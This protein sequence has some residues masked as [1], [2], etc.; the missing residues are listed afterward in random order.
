MS[1]ETARLPSDELAGSAVR[2]DLDRIDF[3]A[4]SKARR[5][6]GEAVLRGIDE[7]HFGAGGGLPGQ[8]LIVV[9]PGV[10]DDQR[11]R[12][13][14]RGGGGNLWDRR[15]GRLLVNSDA[16]RAVEQ[17]ARF[18]G[19]RSASRA[20]GVGDGHDRCEFSVSANRACNGM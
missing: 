10:D 14:F 12:R 8:P 1:A 6:S 7:K 17:D 19:E 2:K 18:E 16:G 5:N 9:E 13:S 20:E 3:A 15:V 4:I 11:P